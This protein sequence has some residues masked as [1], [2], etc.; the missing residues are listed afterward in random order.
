MPDAGTEGEPVDGPAGREA[1]AEDE[2][3]A[4]AAVPDAGT[5]GEPVDRPAG[6]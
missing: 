4:G 5:E 3:A 6:R 1:D 2:P